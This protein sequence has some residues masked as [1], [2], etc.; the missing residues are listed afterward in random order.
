MSK[1]HARAPKDKITKAQVDEA[2]KMGATH[3]AFRN[4]GVQK[5]LMKNQAK[6]LRDQERRENHYK[7]MKKLNQQA[8]SIT[9]QLVE[10]HEILDEV[11][12]STQCAE[13]AAEVSGDTGRKHVLQSMATHSFRKVAATLP[14][15]SDQAPATDGGAGE[16]VPRNIRERIL[17]D[18]VSKMYPHT[19]DECVATEGGIGV[20]KE[21][22][23]ELTD[24]KSLDP[25]QPR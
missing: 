24:T 15:A 14:E 17:D 25:F 18:S 19:I 12:V 13:S 4:K 11:P 23:P 1:S 6:V 10:S 3:A 22:Y 16:M 20:A 9:N 2:I 21:Q 8:E 7:L 5:R